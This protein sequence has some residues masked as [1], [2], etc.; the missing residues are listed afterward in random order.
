MTKYKINSAWHLDTDVIPTAKLSA[1]LK[2]D[3][4]FSN[5]YQDLS[6]VS[7]HTAKFS[8]IGIASFV[9]YLLNNFYQENSNQLA[10][11]YHDRKSKNLLGGVT[12]MTAIAYWLKTLKPNSW[13]NSYGSEVLGIRISHAFADLENEIFSTADYPHKKFLL[14]RLTKKVIKLRTLDK[15]LKYG[16]FHFQGH[17]KNLLPFFL[18]GKLL[19]GSAE[20]FLFMVL[21]IAKIKKEF[22][23]F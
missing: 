7:A 4:V 9:D 10:G 3:L 8:K 15:D 12:D 23:R 11:V 14:L 5:P 19:F 2:L 22:N 20:F 21:A 1:Y 18:Y 13:H 16:S 17:Y 6:A